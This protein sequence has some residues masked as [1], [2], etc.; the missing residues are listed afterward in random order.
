MNNYTTLPY[1]NVVQKKFVKG[2]RQNVKYVLVTIQINFK[3]RKL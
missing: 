3:V 2:N 1:N